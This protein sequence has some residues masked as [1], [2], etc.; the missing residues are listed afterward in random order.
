MIRY[1]PV[2]GA[3]EPGLAHD[4][5]SSEDGRVW[6]FYLRKRVHFHHGRELSADDVVFTLKRLKDWGEAS[7]SCWLCESIIEVQAL[8][9]LTVCVNLAE[10]NYM[11]PHY[12]SSYPMAVLPQDVYSRNKQED[13]RLYPVGTGPFRVTRHDEGGITLEVFEDYFG[14]GAHLDR[15]EMLYI[16]R[17]MSEGDNWSQW[18]FHIGKIKHY[19]QQPPPNWR[20]KEAMTLGS[21]L[22]AFNL[23]KD[24]PQRHM[25]V[26][27]A[28]NRILDREGL[29]ARLEMHNAIPARGFLPPDSPGESPRDHEPEKARQL[30]AACG[31]QGECLSMV[32][33]P[34]HAHEADWIRERCAEVGITIELRPYTYDEMSRTERLLE[35]DIILGGVVADDDEARCLLEMYK[36]R[37]MLIR[38]CASDE[39]RAQ[40]DAMIRSIVA[41]PDG[42]ERMRQI[43][44]MERILTDEYHVLFLVHTTQQTVFSPHLKGISVNTLGWFDFK[45]IWFR[46]EFPQE[47]AVQP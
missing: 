9:R 31:Y 10:S 23:R 27:K 22:L 19:Q 37:N 11:F 25:L 40:F 33:S 36:I 39:S 24:G 41:Q 16:P 26:R 47:A 6:T 34:S 38:V 7:P 17:V 14:E 35:G 42:Q 15:V 21:N 29:I 4:W 43:R 28:L 5:R 46:P 32:F 30:L 18:N 1:N 13:L 2:K 45:S 3:L 20:I 12:V 8:D 44:A